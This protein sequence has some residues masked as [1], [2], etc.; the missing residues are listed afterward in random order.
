LNRA[1]QVALPDFHLFAD[2]FEQF[3]ELW[4][5]AGK[6]GIFCAMEYKIGNFFL[7]IFF[8]SGYRNC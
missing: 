8:I 4:G 1:A 2:G 3:W 6:K 7:E 5:Q